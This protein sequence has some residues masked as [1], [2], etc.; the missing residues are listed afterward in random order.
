[1]EEMLKNL[2][3]NPQ[4]I[5]QMSG[6]ISALQ[7]KGTAD[8]ESENKS[9]SLPFGLDNPDVL[10]KLGNAFGKITSDND[11]RINLLMAIRPYLNSKRAND[12]EKA[13]Q[14]LK[15]SK[16]SSVFEELKIL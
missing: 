12:A 5:E 9:I 8:T 6:L 7:S 15:L 10:I 13:M 14:L 11:P 16:I 3:E 4:A 2:L 1:M